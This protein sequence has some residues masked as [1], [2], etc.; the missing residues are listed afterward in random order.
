MKFSGIQASALTYQHIIANH[1]RQR[2]LESALFY[3]DK[4]QTVHKLEPSLDT[5]EG[6][7]R[8]A[9]QLG[10]SRLAL[11]LAHRLE[12]GSIRRLQA[13]TVVELLQM[14]ARDRYVRCGFQ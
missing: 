11:D 8:L 13:W 9:A 1:C 4:M 12:S 14:F 6:I 10:E 3:L 2:N 7:V 5:E